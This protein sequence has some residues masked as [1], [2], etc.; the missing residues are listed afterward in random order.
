[1]TRQPP[2]P[3][4]VLKRHTESQ[5]GAG[6]RNSTV[7]VAIRRRTSP[8]ARTSRNGDSALPM[9]MGTG[10]ATI[11]PAG[12]RRLICGRCNASGPSAP[13]PA[14]TAGTTTEAASPRSKH[15]I[16]AVGVCMRR[17]PTVSEGARRPA[18]TSSSAS[19]GRYDCDAAA[20]R[21][22]GPAGVCGVKLDPCGS[23]CSS[24]RFRVQGSK[25][26][27]GSGFRVRA[28]ADSGN[29]RLRTSHSL[30]VQS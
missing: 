11:T 29:L 14:R 3:R 4:R 8:K 16:D 1:M 5:S 26:V 6:A 23:A 7:S 20:G 2:V 21:G 28:A 18:R 12:E 10:F 9:R 25:R 13:S 27:R 17:M 30:S 19:R 24:H 22:S 15:R